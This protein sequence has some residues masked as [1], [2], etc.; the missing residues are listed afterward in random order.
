MLLQQILIELNATQLR[1]CFLVQEPTLM[2]EKTKNTD[3]ERIRCHLQECKPEV[4]VQLNIM[5]H[6]SLGQHPPFPQIFMPS[7]ETAPRQL[8]VSS[9]TR[10]RYSWPRHSSI[11]CPTVAISMLI[12]RTALCVERFVAR[13]GPFAM[14]RYSSPFVQLSPAWCQQTT[15]SPSPPRPHHSDHVQLMVL[16]DN[17]PDTQDFSP[18]LR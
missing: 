7:T 17:R 13:R 6:Q 9:S 4:P 5:L 1:K 2:F 14:V 16:S 15:R 12:P 11:G 18:M 3:A 8:T 10:Q